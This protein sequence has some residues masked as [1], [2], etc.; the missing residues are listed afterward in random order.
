MIE[1]KSLWDI[2]KIPLDKL[3]LVIKIVD[4]IMANKERYEKVVE[5]TNIPWYV[6]AAIHYRESSLN[7]K[8]H[9]HNGDPLNAR[10]VQVP[11]GRPIAGSPPFT[12]EESA[13]DAITYQR[14][15]KVTDWSIGNMLDVLEKYN[16]LG[17][18][19]KG[20]PSPYLW[21]FTTNYTSGKYVADG[22][23]SASTVDGQCGVAPIIK[24]LLQTK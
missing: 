21:S 7:Y 13:K 16:G 15:D 24:I 3:P 12:W 2:M 10:T 17:Y 14:L 19:K 9:I 1:N 22:K 8:R 20:L 6:I 5:G 4:K 11:K 23:F 18:K